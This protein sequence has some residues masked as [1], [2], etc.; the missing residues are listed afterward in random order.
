MEGDTWETEDHRNWTDVN[1]KSY[2][3]PLSDPFPY[4]IATGEAVTQSA[5]IEF[6]GD[7]PAP[8]PAAGDAPVRIE[9]EATAEGTVPRIGLGVPEVEAAGS[10]GI[11]ELVCKVAPQVL[12]FEYN[13]A[14]GADALGHFRTRSDAV[15]VEAVLH[16]VLACAT[17]PEAK[18][19]AIAADVNAVG[20]KLD[21]ILPCSAPLLKYILPGAEP[22]EMPT[23]KAVYTA[24]R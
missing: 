16:A 18:L 19:R 12:I 3:R 4:T 20:L 23:L 6:S 15:C 17:E 11:A 10:A 24:A 9:V 14:E 21:A 8:E 7:V 5:T 2:S 22:P 1:F 13:P